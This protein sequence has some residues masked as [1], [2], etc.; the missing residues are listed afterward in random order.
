MKKDNS[1]LIFIG[2]LAGF[3]NG[4][5]GSG[6]G[7]II[8]PSLVFLVKLEDYKAHATAISIILPFTII[9]TLVYLLNNSIPIKLSLFVA[10]GGIAG[11]FLGAKYLKKIPTNILRKI[12]GSVIIYTAIRMIL[13]WN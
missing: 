13:K 12:F 7:T 3:I 5:F 4:I 10:L 8:V 2:L 1:K 6:G 9:S 11:S